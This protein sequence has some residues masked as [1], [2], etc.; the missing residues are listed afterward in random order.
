MSTSAAIALPEPHALVAGLVHALPEFATVKW[1][2]SLGSTN[3]T[4]MDETRQSNL[5]QASHWPRLIGAHHQTAGRGRAGRPWQDQLDQAL[6][7]SCG[8]RTNGPL[9]ALSG[10]APALG[11]ASAEVI[12]QHLVGAQAMTR[13]KWPND[14][15][16]D[17]GKLGGIL[18]ESVLR[19]NSAEPVLFLV[20][21]MGVN[22]SGHERMTRALKRSVADLSQGGVDIDLVRLISDLTKAWQKTIDTLFQQGFKPFVERLLPL[23]FLQGKAVSVTQQEKILQSGLASGVTEQGALALTMADGTVT[24][25]LVGDV[26]IRWDEYRH[27]SVNGSPSP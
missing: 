14:L 5:S 12:N 25:V 18:V 1:S 20:V 16:L 10:L 3:Q 23:D 9:Q 4:L 11:I 21:G 19:Q 15:M 24:Q 27:D 26:S 7:F 8:F 6:M 2:A 13:V 22:L 17:Q